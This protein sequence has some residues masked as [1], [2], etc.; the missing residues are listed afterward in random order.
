MVRAARFQKMNTR[1]SMPNEPMP[2]KGNRPRIDTAEG[3]IAV[4]APVAAVYKRWLAFDDLPKF[5]PVIKRV[6]KLDAN[7]FVASFA[8]NRKEYEATLEIT[9]RVP[10]R[11]LAW[12]TISNSHAHDHLAAGV[13]SFASLSDHGTRVTLKLTSNMG[14]GISNRVDKYLRNF[15]RLIEEG[16]R[17]S[18]DV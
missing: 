1:G 13:V 17:K 7:H 14:G 12:R 4:N 8:L 6:R 5:I 16:R 2:N 10:E 3:S 9:L 18:K 11:R 15:K